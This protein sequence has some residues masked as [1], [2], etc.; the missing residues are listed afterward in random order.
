MKKNIV[1]MLLFL[2]T[3]EYSLHAM[4]RRNPCVFK[5]FKVPRVL[6]PSIPK[7]NFVLYD[8][9]SVSALKDYQAYC[10]HMYASAWRLGQP[11]YIPNDVT[12]VD[13]D[14]QEVLFS[15]KDP[16]RGFDLTH[17]G[18]S[19]INLLAKRA[20]ELGMLLDVDQDDEEILM[21]TTKDKDLAS[22]SLHKDE[23]LDKDVIAELIPDDAYKKREKELMPDIAKGSKEMFEAEQKEKLVDMTKPFLGKKNST[24]VSAKTMDRGNES[25]K[26]AQ[27]N[28]KTKIDSPDS[29]DDR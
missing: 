6:L 8:D 19:K 20:Q 26:N 25:K 9:D 12:K 10:R 21:D 2:V 16:E 23:L 28:E 22:E 17:S 3:D 14:D 27:E 13:Y 5:K 18:H 15:D 1:V 29:Q 4:L 24:D 7:E 11:S